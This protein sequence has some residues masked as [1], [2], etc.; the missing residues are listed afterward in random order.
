MGCTW[1]EDGI[2]LEQQ[3]LSMGVELE[4]NIIL[5]APT[6]GRWE[7]AF[8]R[9]AEGKSD[10]DFVLSPSQWHHTQRFQDSTS[11]GSTASFAQ[12]YFNWAGSWPDYLLGACTAAGAFFEAALSEVAWTVEAGSGASVGTVGGSV[13]LRD[14][15]DERLRAT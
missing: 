10:G 14:N 6:T 13:E 5:V 3:I 15:R 9:N 1:T 8:P 2:L 11:V 12:A 7:E 4:V